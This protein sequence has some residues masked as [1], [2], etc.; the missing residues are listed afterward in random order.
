MWL[1]YSLTIAN[2]PVEISIKAEILIQ[3]SS[4]LP[5]NSGDSSQTLLFET[6][7]YTVN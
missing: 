6:L 2:K 7:L 1:S 4:N 5:L 3:K